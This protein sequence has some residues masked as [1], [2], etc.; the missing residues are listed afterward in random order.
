MARSGRF[1]VLHDQLDGLSTTVVIRHQP[2]RQPQAWGWLLL[3]PATDVDGIEWLAPAFHAQA[4]L[5]VAFA[6]HAPVQHLEFTI[7]QGL[8]E[9]L[10]PRPGIAQGFGV[11]SIKFLGDKF[12]ITQ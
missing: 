10:P 9:A 2:V 5:E 3:M 1:A 8:I 6:D 4:Q 11:G 7:E 12:A